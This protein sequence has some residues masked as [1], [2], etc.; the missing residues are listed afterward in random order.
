[1]KDGSMN[2]FAGFWKRAGAFTFDYMIILFYLVVITLVG[3]LT[4]SLSGANQWLFADRVRAQ[5][6]GFLLITLPVT[7]YFALS[8]ASVRQATWGKKKAGLQVTDYSGG[9]IRFGR[10]LL[11]TALKF[12]PWELSHTLIW[13]I[14]FM[15]NAVSTWINYGFI[16]V[17]VLIGLNLASLIFTGKH[18]TIYDFLARTHV[19]VTKQQ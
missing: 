13:D 16:L 12:I 8:E 14:Y 19:V 2:T 4:N 6:T 15:P 3:L 9:R 5:M 18:Q 10:S 7:L 11:R 17:Y 1:M